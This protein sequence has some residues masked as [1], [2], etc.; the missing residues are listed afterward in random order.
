MISTKVLAI[1]TSPETDRGVLSLLLHPFL[2]GLREA[3]ADTELYYTCDPMTGKCRVCDDGERLRQKIGQADVLVLASPLYF[4]GRTGP[5][6][7]TLSLKLLLE[8]MTPGMHISADRPCEPAV[9]AVRED[10]NLSKVIIPSGSGFWE[11]CGFYPVAEHVKALCHNTFPEF[12]GSIA[13]TRG[14]LLRGPMPRGMLDW[15][16]ISAAR[17][18]G[19]QLAQ[20]EAVP[21]IPHDIARRE[22]VTRDYYSQILNSSI[23]AKATQFVMPVAAKC[24][25]K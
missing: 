7:A 16:I 9:H 5:E 22:A 1:N 19:C 20:D 17:E 25:Q 3:R 24:T 12:A 23:P 14:V 15:D 10:V 11:I 6:G 4:D 21:P 2:D 18:A 13:G 8:G